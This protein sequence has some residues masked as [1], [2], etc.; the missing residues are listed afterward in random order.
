MSTSTGSASEGSTSVVPGVGVG[1]TL[2]VG[3]TDDD[4]A[5]VGFPSG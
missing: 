3:G 5:G 2:G 4:A 1:N